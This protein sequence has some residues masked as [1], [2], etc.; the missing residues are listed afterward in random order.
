MVLVVVF[1][2]IYIKLGG[3][4]IIIFYM[5]LVLLGVVVGYFGVW[6]VY[7][8]ELFL[9]KYCL[10]LFG[11]LFNGGRIIFM[12]VIFVIVGIVFGI[13]GMMIIFYILIVVFVV[14]VIVWLFLLEMLNNKK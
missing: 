10:L 7:Y 12:F 3:D 11:M 6:G 13:L 1:V 2:F 8:I 4:N 9:S 14:G 5:I